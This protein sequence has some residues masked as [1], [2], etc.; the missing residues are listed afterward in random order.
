[1]ILASFLAALALFVVV[2]L[3]SAAKSRGTKVDYY[4]ASRNATYMSVETGETVDIADIS[5]SRRGV[6]AGR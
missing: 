2:G 4:L 5:A 6:A 1:M 3:A